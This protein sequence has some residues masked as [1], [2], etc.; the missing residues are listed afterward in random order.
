MTTKF[1][2][3]GFSAMMAAAGLL[4]G[5]GESSPAFELNGG[6]PEVHLNDT[7]TPNDTWWWSKERS[8]VCVDYEPSGYLIPDTKKARVGSFIDGEGMTFYS[9]RIY[10]PLEAGSNVY[11][12]QGVRAALQLTRKDG[13][14]NVV[15]LDYRPILLPYDGSMDRVSTADNIVI[16]CEGERMVKG[17]WQKASCACETAT[18][19]HF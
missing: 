5:C 3:M 7:C 18:S 15:E 13:S 16:K 19:C 12:Q 2:S 14:S 4:G 9:L 17:G 1:L 6:P 11:T 10:N 8:L